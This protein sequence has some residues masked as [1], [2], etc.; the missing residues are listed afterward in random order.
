MDPRVRSAV[1]SPAVIHF[2]CLDTFALQGVARSFGSGA[3]GVRLTREG[4]ATHQRPSER[5]REEEA[6]EEAAKAELDELLAR[7]E[8]CD[9]LV[10]HITEPARVIM[11]PPASP[12]GSMPSLVTIEASLR[13]P[14]TWAVALL[15]LGVSFGVGLARVASN[16]AAMD[17][18]TVSAA[19]A[20]RALESVAAPRAVRAESA[21]A[22]S[23]TAAPITIAMTTIVA[24]R[25]HHHNAA[26]ATAESP[27][28]AAAPTGT[29]AAPVAD[30][31]MNDGDESVAA[32]AA[33]ARAHSELS[34]SL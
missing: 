33:A 17:P 6:R 20:P 26:E 19:A 24:R 4:L 18:V 9:T 7:E 13:R 10:P 1:K 27:D 8:K 16:A 2:K 25:H 15:T 21:I 29:L 5:A 22:S 12:R 11:P 28:V 14:T 3:A 31:K 32:A 23:A 30:D 34:N